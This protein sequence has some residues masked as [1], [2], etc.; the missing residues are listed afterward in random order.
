HYQDLNGS[1]PKTYLEHGRCWL[2]SFRA[3]WAVPSGNYQLR[4]ELGTHD[5]AVQFSVG[6]G[7]FS[8]YLSYENYKLSNFIQKK[9]KRKERR[10]GNGRTIGVAVHDGSIWIDLWKDPMEWD[11]ND[12]KWWS[13]TINVIDGLLG[14]PKYS[15]QVLESRDVEVPM[16][17]RSYKAKAKLCLDTWSRPRWFSKVQK[18]IDIELEEPIPH[19]GKG[20]NSWDCGVDGRSEEHTSELQSRENLV[21]RLLLEKKKK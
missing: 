9:T 17:E 1:T 7:L 13:T 10:Y 5:E 19:Q 12:P 3:E 20:E 14:K 8:L 11:S 2:G 21:C 18:S 15:R 6:V 4:V 16:P